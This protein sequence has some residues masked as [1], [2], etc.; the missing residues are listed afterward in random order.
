MNIIEHLQRLDA[1]IIEHTKPP[2]TPILRRELAFAIEQ[3]EAY[4]AASDK[5]DQTLSAQVETIER[6][7]K[8][9]AALKPKPLPKQANFKPFGSGYEPPMGM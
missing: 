3:C 6:L 2:V 8:E 7:M 5:Q 1:L 9:N 4:Q